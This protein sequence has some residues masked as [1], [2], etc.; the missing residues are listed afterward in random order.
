MES[1]GGSN[2]WSMGPFDHRTLR[3]GAWLYAAMCLLLA[4][5]FLTMP[6]AQPLTRHYLVL[7]VFCLSGWSVLT[8]ILVTE[9][10]RMG[11]MVCQY[12]RA[13]TCAPGWAAEV[14]ETHLAA[15]G[16]EFER[17]EGASGWGGL[18]E[19]RF[20]F[21]PRQGIRAAIRVRGSPG[22]RSG[23]SMFL[24]GSAFDDDLFE[25]IMGGID[26]ALSMSSPEAPRDGAGSGSAEPTR[27]GDPPQD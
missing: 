10:E 12:R 2:G 6:A 24:E 17:S 26:G 16:V 1:T 8:Y 27:G 18:E 9:H 3:L 20:D 7:L 15:G 14:V 22:L 5:A 25:K 23:R 11:D 4:A 13:Y 19:V 21:S